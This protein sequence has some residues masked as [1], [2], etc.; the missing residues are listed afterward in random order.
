M[1]T[2]NIA[3]LVGHDAN[4]LLPALEAALSL[5]QE[6]CAELTEGGTSELPEVVLFSLGNT[7]TAAD[8]AR[9][10]LFRGADKA[11]V[12]SDPL[13]EGRD[14]SVLLSVVADLLGSRFSTVITSG[15]S[16]DCRP[17]N[18]HLVLRYKRAKTPLERSTSDPYNHIYE[19]RPH[20]T[21]PIWSATD[22]G[23][24][25]DN[26]PE[27]LLFS[28]DGIRTKWGK[29]SEPTIIHFE[30]DNTEWA[31]EVVQLLF[32]ARPARLSRRLRDAQLVVGGGYGVG[33]A[34]G[35]ES[36]SNFASEI[37]ARMGATRAAVDAEFCPAKLMIGPTGE[38]IHPKV[39]I[40]CGISGQVQH[41]A[42]IAEGTTIISINTDPEAPIVEL[43]DWVIVGSIEEVVPMLLDKYR[44]LRSK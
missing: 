43:A 20:L 33:S 21:I 34:E 24:T 7:P 9:E 38:R 19:S 37:K 35:F 4:E 1:N 32:E 39:Y 27:A 16:N 10:G 40:A 28:G 12:I 36:L 42:G 25:P 31:D 22:I 29:R 41:I 44:A 3:L 8:N 13:F 18:A 30:A 17:R 5:R 26:I 2:N 11:V 6:R 15:Q 14:E 23:L